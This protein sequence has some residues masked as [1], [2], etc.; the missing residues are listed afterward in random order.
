[1]NRKL[2]QFFILSIVTAFS[3]NAAQ[4]E[5]WKKIDDAG[6]AINKI[7][8][9]PNTPTKYA[10]AS[11]LYSWSPD[12]LE[13][14]FYII[15]GKG[16]KITNDKGNSFGQP[17]LDSLFVLDV[18]QIDAQ[19]MI[20]SCVNKT[21]G[22][23]VKST[24][25]GIS[26]NKNEVD[27]N[28]TYFVTK[29]AKSNNKIF[30]SA[31]NTAKGILVSEDNFDT[32]SADPQLSI[33]SRDIQVSKLDANMIFVAGDNSYDGGVMRSIDGGNSWQSF[34]S[35]IEG[36]RIHTVLPSGM[37]KSI[38]YCGADSITS[39]GVSFGKGIY[40][41]LDTGKTWHSVGASGAKIYDLDFH[42]LFPK[43]MVAAAGSQGIYVSANNGWWWEQ[44][45]IP[46]Q[47]KI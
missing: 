41:S 9:F 37:D 28:N 33:S 45:S 24:D 10:V 16:F 1:M 6:D 23:I 44:N 7:I 14:E 4:A 35:G 15:E 31:M 40:Q 20:A 8:I 29:F 18:M 3:Y 17:I 38:V 36:L 30:A 21:R 46:I 47:E 12:R 42:P 32:F 19:N 34:D 39:E 2:L 43:F 13:P 25:G 26:W 27:F 11:D 22:S 5:D